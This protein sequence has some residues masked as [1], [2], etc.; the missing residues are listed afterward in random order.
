MPEAEG[1]KRRES[2]AMSSAGERDDEKWVPWR[3]LGTLTR[4]ILVE[5]KT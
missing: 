4:A 5:M 3:F 2:S 1:S